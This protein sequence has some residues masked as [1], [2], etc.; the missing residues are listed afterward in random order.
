MSG[1]LDL[2]N[3]P[4]GKQIISGVAGQTNQPENKTADVLSMALPILM[5]AMKRNAKYSRWGPRIVQCSFF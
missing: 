2:L 4:M 3:S 1:L 5:G